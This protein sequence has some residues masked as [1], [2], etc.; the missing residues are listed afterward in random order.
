MGRTFLL[1]GVLAGAGCAKQALYPSAP[2]AVS[3]TPG[4]EIDLSGTY[5]QGMGWGSLELVLHENGRYEAIY[6]HG[7]VDLKSS[8][9]GTWQRLE[10]VLS[11]RVDP[12]DSQQVPQIPNCFE[13]LI[14]QGAPILLNEFHRA[15]FRRDG[16]TPHSCLR[17]YGPEE[18]NR[19]QPG[20]PE[21][22]AERAA[23]P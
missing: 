18:S 8:V 13:I 15:R 16:V 9:G 19:L 6:D 23:A 4:Q 5:F 20:A 1:L 7:D 17:Q 12:G 14:Y 22:R 2:D 3:P 11:L 21:S 10:N